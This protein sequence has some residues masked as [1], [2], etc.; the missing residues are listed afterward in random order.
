M[1]KQEAMMIYEK[2][3]GGEI[4]CQ[5]PIEKKVKSGIQEMFGAM[6][7]VYWQRCFEGKLEAHIQK[8]KSENRLEAV[9]IL[10][11]N[12][13]R[14]RACEWTQLSQKC[15]TYGREEDAQKEAWK[16]DQL[17]SLTGT[18]NEFIEEKYGY[19]IDL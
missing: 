16:L 3:R 13:A 19:R 9:A 7:R 2:L 11:Q 14:Q 18:F 15:V 6:F 12:F 4:H 17:K 1:E 10:L 5:D 8:P